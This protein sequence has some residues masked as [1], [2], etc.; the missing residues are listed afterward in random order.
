MSEGANREQLN[1]YA[2]FKKTLQRSM[3]VNPYIL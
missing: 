2:R 3:Y 1:P